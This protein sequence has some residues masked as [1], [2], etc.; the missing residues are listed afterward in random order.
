[1]R[2]YAAAALQST[3]WFVRT[4]AYWRWL[5]S[6]KEFDQI[7]VA[8]EGPDRLDADGSGT[9]IVG[10]AVTRE[11][12]IL[13]LFVDPAYP[14]ASAHLLARACGEAIERD[15]CAVTLHAAP[16][17]PLHEL[18]RTA[19]GVQHHHEAH[20]GEVFMARLLDPYGLL[21][22][23][24]PLLFRR[25]EER[26]LPRPGE[27]GLRVEGSKYRLAVSRRAVKAA[28]DRIGRSYLSL[29]VAEFTRLVLGHVDPEEALASG[30]LE[31]STR[32]AVQT[33]Q[34]L[35]PRLPMWRP[36]LDVTLA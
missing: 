3:G 4:E 30:R 33:A 19:R 35:F 18:F 1:M 13:E 11:D 23:L 2:L 7:F 27:L 5:I 31:A 12:R 16:H 28:G 34:A 20:Q 21:R 14:A 24:C 36:P 10:Y 29:N 8:I 26:S 17:D 9:R 22:R 6:R 32:V 25:A 15:M